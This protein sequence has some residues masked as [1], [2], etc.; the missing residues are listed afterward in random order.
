MALKSQMY[1]GVISKYCT[2]AKIVSKQ[3]AFQIV[4]F[5][6]E[7]MLDSPRCI[8]VWYVRRFHYY[9]SGCISCNIFVVY[10]MMRITQDSCTLLAKE[11]REYRLY[12]KFIPWYHVSS[13]FPNW[14]SQ[15]ITLFMPSSGLIYATIERV[16]FNAW[17][18]G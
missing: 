14:G 15:N 8:D 16:D 13:F 9:T 12:C 11:R 10:F 17:L 4:F 7:L 1:V 18:R 6:T 5:S 2:T 3:A